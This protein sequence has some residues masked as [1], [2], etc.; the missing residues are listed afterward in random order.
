L[1]AIEVKESIIEKVRKTKY[2]S[3]IL[4]CAPDACHQEQMSFILRCVNI[5]ENPIKVEEH[6]V[7]FITVN[8][9]TGEGLFI[10]MIGLIKILELNISDIRGQ[11]YDNGSNMKGK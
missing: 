10:E 3:I 5:S 9:T 4:D 11:G 6:F 1:L 7:K 8:D 2:F